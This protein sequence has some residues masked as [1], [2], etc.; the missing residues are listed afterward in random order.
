MKD[1]HLAGV[2]LLLYI[3]IAS[4]TSFKLEHILESINDFKSANT[5]SIGF[6]SGEFEG[7]WHFF[8]KLQS[9]I[10]LYN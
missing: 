4:L 10:E 8:E 6:K 3:L 9:N 1:E 7:A 2:N 5:N